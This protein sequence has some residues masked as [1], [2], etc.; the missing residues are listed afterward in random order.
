MSYG[1]MRMDNE[2]EIEN[3]H[4]FKAPAR[5]VFLAFSDAKQLPQWWGP[6]GYTTTIDKMDFREGGEWRFVQHGKEGREFAFH[7]VY[8][9]IVYGR[10][11]VQT[12]E[13]E[14]TPGRVN[15][16]TATFEER[17]GW[18]K[19]T[20][21]TKFQSVSDRDAMLK[22]GMEKGMNEGWEKLEKLVEKDAMA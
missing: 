8:K 17:G 12:F 20:I 3:S 15:E 4:D 18:T 9:E 11:I 1:V 5:R 13:Y 14:G 2:P 22:S 21:K 19:V 16:D 6:Q 7:G 10:K